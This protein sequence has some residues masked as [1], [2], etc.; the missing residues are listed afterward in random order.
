[1]KNSASNVLYL[2]L[3]FANIKF[4]F[5]MFIGGF[6]DDTSIFENVWWFVPFFVVVHD[7]WGIVPQIKFFM[8]I[9]SWLVTNI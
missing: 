9:K 4:L 5:N 6:I 2:G 7:L 8:Y 1:M 3:T